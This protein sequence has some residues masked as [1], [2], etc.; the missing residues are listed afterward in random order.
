MR[1][2]DSQYGSGNPILQEAFSAQLMSQLD[3]L[4]FPDDMSRADTDVITQV[5]AIQAKLSDLGKPMT[6][7]DFGLIVIEKLPGNWVF[8]IGRDHE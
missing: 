7:N 5:D 4:S 2:L 8:Q 6:D 1:H 3:R